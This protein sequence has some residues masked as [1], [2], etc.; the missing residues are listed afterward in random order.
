[1]FP[2]FVK[3]GLIN[4]DVKAGSVDGLEGQMNQRTHAVFP[5]LLTVPSVS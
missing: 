1:M 3:E 4:M 5:P 2:M